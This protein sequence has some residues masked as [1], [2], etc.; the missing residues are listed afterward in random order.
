VAESFV[1]QKLAFC[2]PQTCELNRERFGARV[3]AHH[4]ARHFLHLFHELC[5]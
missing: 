1:N 4:C 2:V 3:R 5:E